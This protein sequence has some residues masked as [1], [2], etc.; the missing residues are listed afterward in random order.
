[1]DPDGFTASVVCRIFAIYRIQPYP[2]YL[3]WHGESAAEV[4]TSSAFQGLGA[5]F[6]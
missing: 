3:E 6:Y 4:Y 5:T 2:G 1:M